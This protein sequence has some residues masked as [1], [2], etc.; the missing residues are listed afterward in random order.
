MNLIQAIEILR[1]HNEWRRGA[2]IPMQN[3]TQLGIAIEIILNHLDN[4]KPKSN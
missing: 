4:G 1:T 3:Q 2:D